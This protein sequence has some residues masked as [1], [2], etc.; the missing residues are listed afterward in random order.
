MLC[1]LSTHAWNV[2]EPEQALNEWTMATDKDIQI[3][4]LKFKAEDH[5]PSALLPDP[6]VLRKSRESS[7][8]LQA[9]QK[10]AAARPQGLNGFFEKVG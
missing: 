3:P 1:S 10:Q 9:Q 8:H 6:S 2:A 5:F 4:S 7:N